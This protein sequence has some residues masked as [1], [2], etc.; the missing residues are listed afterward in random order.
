MK[1]VAMSAKRW[2]QSIVVIALLFMSFAPTGSALAW[3]S[4][5]SY[6]T[7]QWG[8]TLSAIASA[9]GITVYSIQVANPGMGYW[10]YA[11]T[12]IYIP[13]SYSAP[14]V[15]YPPASGTY[16][17]Q[18]GDTLGKIARRFGVSLKSLIAA[19]PQISNPSLIY[20]GQV[21]SLPATTPVYYIVQ[22]GDTLR[23]IAGRYGTSVNSLISLN[24][25]IYNPNLIY[26]G[27]SIRVW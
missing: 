25:Q 16:V 2:I 3:Y 24:P 1:G 26:V 5:G 19:N 22:Q 14:P 11:G 6:Y 18:S 20:A 7:V 12:T 13:G 8:D 21:I 27:Q 23:K 10:L 4:C 17:V 9:C 15:Y